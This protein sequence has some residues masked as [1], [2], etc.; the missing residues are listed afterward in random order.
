ME[1]LSLSQVLQGLGVIEAKID[2]VLKLAERRG[3]KDAR[4][5]SPTTV[6]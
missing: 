5:E 1:T 2:R 4:Q 3:K 6:H